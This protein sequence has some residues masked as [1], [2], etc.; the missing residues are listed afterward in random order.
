MGRAPALLSSKANSRKDI[1]D[2][3]VIG[4]NLRFL[5]AI[6]YYFHVN[7][8]G[9]TIIVDV[10]C[11]LPMLLLLLIAARPKSFDG[12]LRCVGHGEQPL[13]PNAGTGRLQRINHRHFFAD[14]PKKLRHVALV[15]RR[16]S[17]CCEGRDGGERGGGAGGRGCVGGSNGGGNDSGAQL[18][19]LVVSPSLGPPPLLFGFCL[20][21][22]ECPLPPSL[23]LLAVAHCSGNAGGRC[24]CSGA[25]SRKEARRGGGCVP[26]FLLILRCRSCTSTSGRSRRP[27]T[28]PSLAS[29]FVPTPTPSRDR[30][31]NEVQKLLPPCDGL[32]EKGLV[33]LELRGRRKAEEL[34]QR[35]VTEL[36]G[37]TNRPQHVD[38]AA[39]AAD[40]DVA[41]REKVVDGGGNV[42]AV[43]EGKCPPVNSE[44]K[45]IA[46]HLLH[47]AAQRTV[48]KRKSAAC[49]IRGCLLL[50]SSV[51]LLLFATFSLLFQND[52]LLDRGHRVV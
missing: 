21:H 4:R 51:L 39:D 20:S 11:T 12:G 46:R 24:G 16:R 50:T 31:A 43:A 1:I 17:D 14:E 49:L 45:Q 3:V 2:V 25:A 41:H 8:A 28:Q 38:F 36:S 23:L 19:G 35:L 26:Q 9:S 22:A 29:V 33:V 44:G 52:N 47:P 34:M 10:A 30:A 32:E 48:H 42:W 37:Q 7:A 40:G 18:L 5:L 15:A 13:S 6:N 27:I